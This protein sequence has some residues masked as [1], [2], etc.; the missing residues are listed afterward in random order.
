MSVA[1][2]TVL[3]VPIDCSGRRIGVEKM[4]A[5]LRAAGLVERLGTADAGD[6]AVSIDDSRRDPWTGIIGYR[7][8]CLA[9]VEI[10]R[11]VGAILA[12]GER[13]LVIGGCCTLLIG[14]AAAL[15]NQRGRTAL[16][17]ADGHLDFYDGQTSPSGEAADMDLAILCGF[18]P[19]DLVGL[20]GLAPLISPADIVVLGARDAE[21]AARLGS[22]DPAVLTP[23]M[24]VHDAAAVRG[25]PSGLGRAAAERFAKTP[26]QFW[27][28]FDLD[29]LDEAVMPAVDYRMPGGLDWGEAELLLRPLVGSPALVGIDVTILNPNLDPGGGC[30]QRTVDL[31]VS[32]LGNRN[33]S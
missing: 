18:G 27:L 30:A 13:P 17:F 24:V 29:V 15:R 28:H 31:L 32:L 10:R 5:A 16:A 20:A 2:W 9:S 25:N 22:P 23:S 12:R 11:G 14:V 3:G 8:V 26:G 6:L 4:P 7:D 33:D 19:P 21:Q 1:P